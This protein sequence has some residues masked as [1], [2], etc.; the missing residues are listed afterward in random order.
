MDKFR[1]LSEKVQIC[2]LF[3]SVAAFLSVIVRLLTYNTLK[4][5]MLSV[6]TDSKNKHYNDASYRH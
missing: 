3:I 4:K 5:Q 6:A 2:G 1:F